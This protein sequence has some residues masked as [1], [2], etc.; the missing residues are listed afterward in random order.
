[1]QVKTLAGFVSLL[2]LAACGG[3]GDSDSSPPD[4]RGVWYGVA[5]NN[6]STYMYPYLITQTGRDVVVTGCNRTTTALRLDDRN[7][8]QSDGN[9]FVV[10]PGDSAFLM[11]GG[12]GASA[13]AQWRRFSQGTAFDSGRISLSVPG[14]AALQAT[15]DVCAQKVERRYKLDNGAEIRG[16]GVM[17]TAPYASGHIFVT[18]AFET[19]RTGEF[20][21]RD[22]NG[23]L[24]NLGSAVHIEMQSPAFKAAYGQDTL[25]AASGTVRVGQSASGAYTFDGTVTTT[26]G[27][28][29]P[30]S[31][32]VTLERRP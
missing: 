29:V 14:Q 17:I 31:A 11:T 3:G 1:M 2:F 28:Q 10:Q 20:T 23:F 15:Q 22:R 16:A 13:G 21:A 30:L 6:V 26:T 27:L 12:R 4:L 25:Q 32:E 8:V 5:P 7:L 24:N 19:L 18:L 9:S